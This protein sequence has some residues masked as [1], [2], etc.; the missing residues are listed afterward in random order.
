MEDID[1]IEFDLNY[2]HFKYV[3]LSCSTLQ[4][5]FDS[6]YFYILINEVI[7]AALVEENPNAG[8]NK[9]F[10]LY[11]IILMALPK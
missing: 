7:G 2:N 5:L 4:K 9:K 10:I 1:Y 6:E 8:P 3:L 11:A